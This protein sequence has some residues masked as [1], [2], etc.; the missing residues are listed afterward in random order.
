MT[1]VMI[2]GTFDLLHPGQG[3]CVMVEHRDL[4]AQL[5]RMLGEARPVPDVERVPTLDASGRVLAEAQVS[6][7]DVPP[8]DNS[9]MDG[10]A[11][12]RADLAAPGATLC[13]SQK[14]AAGRSGQP[15]DRD[16]KKPGFGT[17]A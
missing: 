17:R 14:I 8:M 6:G 7:M 2:F 5:A 4:R 15:R 10:Y 12:R 11:V 9:A 1:R 16:S 13:V 3:G